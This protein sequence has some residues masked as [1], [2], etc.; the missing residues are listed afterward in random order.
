DGKSLITTHV[1]YAVRVW[2]WPSME[3]PR[4]VLRLHAAEPTWLSTD[5]SG[6]LLATAGWDNRTAIF[7]LLD[8]RVLMSQTGSRIMAAPDRAAFL[9]VNTG[10]W[11]LVELE[12]ALGL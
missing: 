10:Q 11:R 4:L 2:D 7:D 1:D 3:A 12:P 9:L 8:G 6:R 5:P